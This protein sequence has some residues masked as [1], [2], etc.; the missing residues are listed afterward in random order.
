MRFFGVWPRG[1]RA[2][3]KPQNNNTRRYRPRLEMLEDRLTPASFNDFYVVPGANTDQ[4]PVH[5]HWD[6]RGAAFNNSLIVYTVTNLQGEVLGT[7]PTEDGY[8]RAVS[9]VAQTVFRPGEG[10]GTQRTILF[11]GGT[12]LGFGLVTN[13]PL[14]TW[15]AARTTSSANVY[16]SS[17]AWLSFNGDNPE[18]FDPVLS[19]ELAPGVKQFFFEDHA[20]STLDYTD[21]V[22]TVSPTGDRAFAIPG[23]TGQVTPATF[24]LLGR[25]SGDPSELGLFFVNNMQGQLGTLFPGD[26]GYL[27]QAL[28]PANTLDIFSLTDPVG[29][30]RTLSLPSNRTYGLFLVRGGTL[31]ELLAVNPG[32]IP[33]LGVEAFF[34]FPELNFD[35]QPHFRQLSPGVYGVE[36][37][38]NGDFDFNDLIFRVS[39]GAAFGDVFP[40]VIT[41]QLL[42]DTGV[43]NNDLITA[44]PTVIGTVTDAE[45]AI[46]ALE[47]SVDS[48]D[49]T[50][51]VDI[52]ADF[53]VQTGTFELNRTRLEAILGATLNDGQHT[54]RLR[55]RD[56]AG[57][58]T[59]LF[60][61]TFTFDTTVTPAPTV[62]LAAESDSG[63]QGDLTTFLDDVTLNGSTEANATVM[64]NG[65]NLPVGGLTATSDAQGQFT[66]TP[67]PLDLGAN[68]Y[69][70]QVTDRAGNQL[71][72]PFAFTITQV[73]NSVPTFTGTIPDI[74]ANLNGPP[75]AV[76]LVQF[77][78][79]ADTGHSLV[80]F[81]VQFGG[82]TNTFEFELFDREAPA[83]VANFLNYIQDG[84]YDD[85]IFHRSAETL[86][87]AEFVLQGGGYTFD[88]TPQFLNIPE[89]P[90]VPNEFSAT[91]SNLRGTVAMAKQGN[92]PNSASSEFFVNLG[93]NSANLDNQNGGFTVFGKVFAGQDVI[94]QIAAQPTQDREPLPDPPADQSPFGE[95]PVFGNLGAGDIVDLPPTD[96]QFPLPAGAQEE[97]FATIQNVQVVRTIDRLTFTIEIISES[98][99]GFVNN[100]TVLNNRL[101]IDPTQAGT[102]TVQIRATDEF[103]NSVVSNQFTITIT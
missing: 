45:S 84:R 100:V 48:T 2:T 22:F 67:L 51:L 66:F 78:S 52:F 44:D 37:T 24:D 62:T 59:Q 82:Q 83:T 81:D 94:D 39:Y 26:E 7:A 14:E 95:L 98:T 46:V 13:A 58:V 23:L 33:G 10:T 61:F 64:L 65:P 93:N 102:A 40:P 97:N 5:F 74:S 89:D 87:G 80:R 43:L 77:F 50:D 86:Q 3:R 63:V 19:N 9:T 32:N 29:T 4:V 70:L 1:K 47:A 91:R 42:N 101:I 49:P 60:P 18:E 69:T 92:D 79:D 75:Q 56:S 15:R 41:A 34:F 6:F 53:D 85:S 38:T 96:G 99:P 71:A 35:D 72:A 11:A 76:E 90:N 54:V 20:G 36:D 68:N 55:A 8:A 57:N 30:S 73:A 21:M 25:F 27:E 103:G 17:V 12:I 88:T 28:T 16:G 31:E